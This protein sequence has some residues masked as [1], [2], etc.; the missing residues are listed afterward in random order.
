M[1]EIGY[2]HIGLTKLPQNKCALIIHL[3]VLN[4]ITGNKG[5]WF[6]KGKLYQY[7]VW[8][9]NSLAD[10]HTLMEYD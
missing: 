1:L 8:L 9:K 2:F 3:S 6:E 4:S 7:K 5:R 10:Q